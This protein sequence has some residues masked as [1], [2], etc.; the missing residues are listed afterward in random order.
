MERP[1]RKTKVVNYSVVDQDFDDDEDFAFVK[2]PPSK[3]PR[4][5]MKD[6]EQEKPK[7]S[8]SK[9]SSQESD[10]QSLLGCKQRV[11][12]HDKLYN[13]DLEAALTLS[14]LQN[15]DLK[16]KHCSTYQDV[17]NQPQT[18]NENIDPALHLTNCSVDINVLGLD[19]ITSEQGSLC[20][21]SRQRKPACTAPEKQRSMLKDEDEDYQPIV[22]IDAESEDDFSDQAESEDKEFSLKKAKKI[23]KKEKI[24][25]KDRSKPAQVSRKGTLATTKPSQVKPHLT[26]N[27]TM[28]KSRTAAKPAPVSRHPSTPP[29]SRSTV[30]VSPTPAGGRIPKWNPPAQIGGSPGASQ[31]AEGKSPGQGLRLGL[32]RRMRVKPLH[33][34]VAIH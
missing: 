23:N 29:L 24:P 12:V 17:K 9:S 20:G 2:A 4:E 6:I 33:P 14:L 27:P 19:K 7:K 3:K 5:C 8:S 21:L 31:N 34:S 1:S 18:D 22:T 16:E 13:R 26:T 11:P 15:S 25:Q 32:S 30:S 28:V 10:A